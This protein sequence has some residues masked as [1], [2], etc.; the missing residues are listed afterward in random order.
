MK[1]TPDTSMTTDGDRSLAVSSAAQL[2]HARKVELAGDREEL[3]PLLHLVIELHAPDA[4]AG[5]SPL[6]RRHATRESRR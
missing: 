3:N 6:G 4:N 2:S 1:L 5:D